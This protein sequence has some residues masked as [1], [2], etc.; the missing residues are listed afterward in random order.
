L[1]QE[2]LSKLKILCGEDRQRGLILAQASRTAWSQCVSDAIL[3]Q[4][5]ILLKASQLYYRDT[6]KDNDSLITWTAGE[7]Y[8]LDNDDGT[9]TAMIKVQANVT[10]ATTKKPT[11][12]IVIAVSLQDA[13]TDDFQLLLNKLHMQTSN[14]DGSEDDQQ[15]TKGVTFH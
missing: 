3:S 12:T 5:T 10:N 11:H 13:L 4:V 14:T 2:C 6:T 7:L 1:L 8:E 15:P 9:S